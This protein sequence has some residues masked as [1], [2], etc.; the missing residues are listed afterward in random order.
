MSFWRGSFCVALFGVAH[1]VAEFFG[2]NF[3]KIIFFF[4]QFFLGPFWCDFHE[5]FFPFAFFFYQFFNF[6]KKIEKLEKEDKK[7]V[8][9]VPKRA[10]TK[11]VAP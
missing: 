8:E 11:R 3:K 7:F 1:V 10:T 2:T 6:I 4:F 9:F 5:N